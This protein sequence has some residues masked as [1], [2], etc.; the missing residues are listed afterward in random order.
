MDIHM[1]QE[2]NFEL[3]ETDSVHARA[4]NYTSMFLHQMEVFVIIIKYFCNV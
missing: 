1:F 4:S 2:V 3:Q